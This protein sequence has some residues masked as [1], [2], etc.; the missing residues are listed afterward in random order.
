MRIAILSLATLAAIALWSTRSQWADSY[1]YD[2]GG[3][4]YSLD[5]K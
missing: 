2:G 3:N 5:R 1:S 4:L